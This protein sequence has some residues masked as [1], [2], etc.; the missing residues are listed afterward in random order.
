MMY[1]YGLIVLWHEHIREEPGR[2]VR[3]WPGKR[4]ASFADMLATLRSDSLQK[5]RETILSSAKT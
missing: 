2:F 4:H 5:T 1:L 3:N